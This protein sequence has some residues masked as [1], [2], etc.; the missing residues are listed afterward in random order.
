MSFFW[1]S[2]PF[3]IQNGSTTLFWVTTHKLRTSVLMCEWR[4]SWN[5]VFSNI[6]WTFRRSRQSLHR[7]L[8]G[9]IQGTTEQ[10]KTKL[11]QLPAGWENGW[12]TRYSCSW[13][14]P[15]T[16]KQRTEG[17]DSWEPARSVTQPR[18]SLLFCGKALLSRPSQR[19]W[20]G[21]HRFSRAPALW[22]RVRP[23]R[24]TCGFH[25]SI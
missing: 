12:S 1:T 5:N 4:N 21:F 8:N 18:L 11:P 14:A 25:T 24:L 2:C 17:N 15:N 22:E 7:L 13:L 9:Q 10:Q 3:S 20:R 6:W 23:C 16:W 19:H